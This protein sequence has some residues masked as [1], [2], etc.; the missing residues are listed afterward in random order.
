M[1]GTGAAGA[2]KI[3]LFTMTLDDK[4]Q[5]IHHILT[6]EE[7]QSVIDAVEQETAPVGDS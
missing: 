3:E 6:K 7:T 4:G 2:E 5:V 1:D